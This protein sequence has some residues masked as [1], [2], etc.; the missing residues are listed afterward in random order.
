M[1]APR[2]A[3][4]FRV[5][6]LCSIPARAMIS[7]ISM[8]PS[9]SALAT[10]SISCSSLI[11]G[12]ISLAGA[13]GAASGGVG[14]SAGEGASEPPVGGRMEEGI[15]MREGPRLFHSAPLPPCYLVRGEL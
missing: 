2:F 5:L 8:R 14:S 12:V 7:D 10:T 11:E 15:S 13:E 4:T 3:A 6:E 1:T 9:N